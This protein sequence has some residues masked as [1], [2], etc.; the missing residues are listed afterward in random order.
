MVDVK[1]I[2]TSRSADSIFSCSRS[3]ACER[4]IAKLRFARNVDSGMR[5]A[6]QAVLAESACPSGSL[7]TRKQKFGL[8]I[9]SLFLS[10]LARSRVGNIARGVSGC[11][12][13][14]HAPGHLTGTEQAG[15]VKGRTRC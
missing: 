11:H 8:K 2:I 4:Q 6:K 1:R 7:G 12:A 3:P 9:C 14:E 10:Q 5:D 13:Q 15:Q